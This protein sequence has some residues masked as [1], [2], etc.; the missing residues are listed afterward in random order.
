MSWYENDY[1]KRWFV[2]DPGTIIHVGNAQLPRNSRTVLW[3]IKDRLTSA[4]LG[5]WTVCASCGKAGTGSLIASTADNWLTQED[6]VWS[7]SST[8]DH[9][10]IV[11]KSPA[12][13]AGQFYMVLDYYGTSSWQDY[14]NW[15]FTKA[16]PDI[17][18]P[19]TNVRPPATGNEWDHLN[20]EIV[21]ESG[22]ENL[23]QFV[24]CRAHDG[25]FV[26]GV[27]MPTTAAQDYGHYFRAMTYFNVIAN[28]KSWDTVGAVSLVIS[29]RSSTVWF[30]SA[31]SFKTLHQDGSQV[32][33][34]PVH[35]KG[36]QLASLR[37]A[38]TDPWTNNWF[39]LPVY[40]V[41]I[42]GGKQCWRGML[43]DHFWLPSA[44]SDGQ[45]M[46]RNGMVKAV[47]IGT[48]SVPTDQ[49]MGGML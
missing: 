38:Y 32:T 40:L 7:T 3:A 34:R 28:A 4:G 22:T 9:S 33:L 23:T 45:L 5:A 44:M 11:L 18:S 37:N 14:V 26:M 27:V 30:A 36:E 6:L 19:A 43:E 21:D 1:K 12:R 17:S 46:W 48:F 29:G 47:K 10:W 2:A 39:V 24:L 16:A 15:Y 25:S 13:R 42:D 20:V 35:L 8:V 49:V 31:Q 41:A